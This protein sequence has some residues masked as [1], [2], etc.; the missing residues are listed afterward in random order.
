MILREGDWDLDTAAGYLI[1]SSVFWHF[2]RHGNARP[3]PGAVM[4]MAVPLTPLAI[5][6]GG[7]Y[8]FT[9]HNFYGAA[10]PHADVFR[11]WHRHRL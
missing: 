2:R 8:D 3:A 4:P 11:Q 6:A 10:A 5:K 9:N 7:R 1:V